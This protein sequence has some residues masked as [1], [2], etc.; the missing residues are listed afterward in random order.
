MSQTNMF[1]TLWTLFLSHISNPKLT[2]GRRSDDGSK[3]IHSNSKADP[4]IATT[5]DLAN[6]RWV[7]HV[8]FLLDFSYRFLVRLSFYWFWFGFGMG[9][10][11]GLGW[12]WIRFSSGFGLI[13]SWIFWWFGF[14]LVWF[15]VD[16][17]LILGQFCGGLSTIEMGCSGVGLVVGCFSSFSFLVLLLGCCVC[18]EREGI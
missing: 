11:K 9:F 2:Q 6:L 16:F 13:L 18:W 14:V 5:A 15:S 10:P 8:G 3:H 7:F 1:G 17:G 4:T 12:L